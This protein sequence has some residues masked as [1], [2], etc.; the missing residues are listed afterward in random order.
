MSGDDRPVAPLVADEK[1][2]LTGFLDH[3]R[4]TL[5]WK[6]EDLTPDQMRTAAC[7][8]SDLTLWGLLRHLAEVDRGWFHDFDGA[9]LPPLYCTEENPDGDL[10]I[11]DDA[12]FEAD[13]ATF[14]S[15]C[16]R[17]REIVAAHSLDDQQVTPKRTYSLR[18]IVVHLIEE[19]ARHNGHADLLRQAIDG[20]TGE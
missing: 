18:W 7:P 19:Y 10:A 8:P 5:L 9:D 6:I 20:S 11:P 17:S 2:T 14:R 16:A 15:V 12:D 13:L 3:H 1:M 4:A